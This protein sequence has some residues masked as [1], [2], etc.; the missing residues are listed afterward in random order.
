VT[1]AN[2]TGT[3]KIEIARADQELVHFPS[4]EFQLSFE[5]EDLKGNL[6]KFI[7]VKKSDVERFLNEVKTLDETRKGEARLE[8]IGSDFYLR[9]YSL[10]GAGHLGATLHYKK[11]VTNYSF[12][13]TISFETDPTILPHVATDLKRILPSKFEI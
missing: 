4:Y 10:D 3:R 5:T 7:W 2:E 9:L 12:E 11:G 13:A 1:I 8:S 6:Y